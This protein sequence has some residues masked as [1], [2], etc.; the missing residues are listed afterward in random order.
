MKSL[1]SEC[2]QFK[3]GDLIEHLGVYFIFCGYH[4]GDLYD[5]LY[6]LFAL[7]GKLKNQFITSNL[8]FGPKLITSIDNCI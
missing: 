7:S 5:D 8:D 2:I 4:S 1:V 6:L 3:T